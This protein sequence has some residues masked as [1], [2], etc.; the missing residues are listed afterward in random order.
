MEKVCCKASSYSRKLH[1]TQQWAA[2]HV[3]LLLTDH[4]NMPGCK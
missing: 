2:T 3:K 1:I 4:G